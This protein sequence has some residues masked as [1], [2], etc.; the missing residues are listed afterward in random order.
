MSSE[1]MCGNEKYK[2]GN[3]TIYLP[4]SFNNL[5]EEIQVKG[6]TL[7]LP[8]P[9]HVSLVY[10]GKMIEKYN[11]SIPNFKEKIASDFCEFTKAHDINILRYNEFRF[12]EKEEKK[13]VIVMCEVSNLDKFFDLI[14]KKYGLHIKYMTTHIT[15]YGNLKK[16]SGIWLM[17]EDDI[18]NFTVPIE[19]PIG[20]TL[21]EF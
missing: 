3:D 4:V 8:T 12:V 14:N 20:K 17:D 15:L 16:K 1:F 2:I 13:T 6:Q 7:Y 18:K 19:N 21:K 9:F 10:I 5:P 11:I